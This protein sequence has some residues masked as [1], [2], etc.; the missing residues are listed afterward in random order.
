MREGAACSAQSRVAHTPSRLGQLVLGPSPARSIMVARGHGCIPVTPPSANK[1]RAMGHVASILD[2]V[3]AKVA[4][5]DETL[6]AARGRR[7]A[8]IDAAEAYPGFLRSYMSG[9]IAHGTANDDTDADCGIVLDRR[10]YPELGPD[11]DGEGPKDTV[12][13]VRCH[14]RDVLCED[15]SDLT[16]RVTKRAIMVKFNDPLSEDVDPHVDLIV[17]LNRKDEPGLWIP[18]TER[19]G[20]D[21]SDPETHTSLL[22]AGTRSTRATRA[23]VVR[24]AKAWNNQ[25]SKPGLCSFNIE[26]LALAA[27]DGET[28][29]AQ[30][31]AVLFSHAASD[32]RKHYTPDPAGVSSSIKLKLD[33]DIVVGRLDRA[34]SHMAGAMAAEEDDN[35]DALLDELAN[36]F[37]DYVDAPESSD[38]K[39][40]LAQRLLSDSAVGLAGGSLVR[41]SPSVKP[42][43][44]TQAY[45]GADD[46]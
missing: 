46:V 39:A 6:A 21:A 22:T 40:A 5:C 36:I 35:E 44:S 28:D 26:A 2:D 10:S 7:R 27:L 41:P 19:N 42:L 14:L 12:E 33:R 37:W 17:A 11:G 13:S 43:K 45:G 34:S 18:N 38:S 32:L 15:Y 8:V 31:L 25:Y 24:L 20:W 30:A 4:P 23:R 1:G 3:R 16:F 29:L 9:S